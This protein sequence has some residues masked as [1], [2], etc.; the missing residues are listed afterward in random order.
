MQNHLKSENKNLIKQLFELE[1]LKRQR[2]EN[3]T[4]KIENERKKVE[5]IKLRFEN[6]SYLFSQ[7]W[8]FTFKIK[9]LNFLQLFI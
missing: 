6:F 7:I 4:I 3:E 9:F 2:L 5:I 8:K 1:K